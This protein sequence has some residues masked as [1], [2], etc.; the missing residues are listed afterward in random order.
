MIGCDAGHVE[1]VCL[2]PAP[3]PVGLALAPVHPWRVAVGVSGDESTENEEERNCVVCEDFV[4]CADFPV[5]E[6][7]EMHSHDP[8]LGYDT[9]SIQ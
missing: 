5:Q 8:E 9:E 1:W 3:T 4:P 7:H 6:F 2:A